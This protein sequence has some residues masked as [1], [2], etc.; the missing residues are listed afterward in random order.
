MKIAIGS[1][2]AGFAL[3]MEMIEFLEALGHEVID[4]GPETLKS[5]DY[6]EYAGKVA[7]YV[8]AHDDVRGVVICGTGIGV[9]IVANKYKGIRCALCGDSYT[10]RLTREHNNSNI[11]ALGARVIGPDLAKEIVRIFVETP[12]E[13]G[14]HQHR[15][16]M[17]ATVEEKEGRR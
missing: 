3:R 13:V 16:D 2:H 4:F 9:S 7:K 5:V 14:R 10:A 15:I 11:V 8:R 6:P 1:D 17:I 12:Y